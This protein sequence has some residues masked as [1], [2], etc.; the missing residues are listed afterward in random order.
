VAVT[1]AI[2]VRDD[3]YEHVARVAREPDKIPVS[4]L[5]WDDSELLLRVV[6][7]RYS[8]YQGPDSDPR[9]IWRA[10]FCPTARGME[11]REY[12]LSRILPKP[13]DLIIFCSEAIASAVNRRRSR[14]E[15]DDILRA[16]GLYSQ[17]ALESLNVENGVSIEDLER[18]LLEFAGAS[19]EMSEE[20]VVRHVRDGGMSADQASEVIRRLRELSFL[21]IEVEAGRFDFGTGSRGPGVADAL[22]VRF[23]TT[24]GTTPRYQVHAAFRS[25]LEIRE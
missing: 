2:F 21:G 15:E 17:F 6:E 1:L 16:E 25:Y 13:R 5:Y 20:E 12:V 3:I 23:A 8:I 9:Q 4:R 19:A 7:E 24:S 10:F 22:A 11:T 14:V 18:V